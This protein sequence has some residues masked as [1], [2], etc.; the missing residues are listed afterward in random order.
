MNEE[1][2]NLVYILQSKTLPT[3]DWSDFNGKH[4]TWDAIRRF[5]KIR[6]ETLSFMETDEVP[7]EPDPVDYDDLLS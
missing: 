7:T 3:G 6:S 2:D 1:I 5:A 4:R